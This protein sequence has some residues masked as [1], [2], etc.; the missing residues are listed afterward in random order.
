LWKNRRCCLAN[1][2]NKVFANRII[3]EKGRQE[4]LIDYVL[5]NHVKS[6]TEIIA[7]KMS[8]LLEELNLL[9]AEQEGCHAGS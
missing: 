1:D 5:N 6:P 4:V 3:K 9:P 8:T 7:S 2:K